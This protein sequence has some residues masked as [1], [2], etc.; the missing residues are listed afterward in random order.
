MEIWEPKPPGTFWVT[1]GLLREHQITFLLVGRSFK[2]EIG[3]SR[4]GWPRVYCI[5][6]RSTPGSVLWSSNNEHLWHWWIISEIFRAR[7]ILESWGLRQQFQL[8]SLSL[9]TT[10]PQ[11]KISGF[12]QEKSLK[13]S[14]CYNFLWVQRR[15]NCSPAASF[16]NCV[17]TL[18]LLKV[19]LQTFLS[20]PVT[21]KRQI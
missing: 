3:W 20:L 15:H 14:K 19:H 10:V 16:T 7:I 4:V 11:L 6:Y 13:V 17:M 21:K 18:Y 1:P 2:A 8:T 5:I 12:F 9:A